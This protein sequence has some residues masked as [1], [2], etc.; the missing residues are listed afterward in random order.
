MSGTLPPL[1]E[2]LLIAVGSALGA[3]A[4][5][6][7]GQCLLRSDFSQPVV[8]TL[9]VN[10][11]GCAVAGF[12]AGFAGPS[13]VMVAGFL[14]AGFLGSYTTVSSLSLEALGMWQSGRTRL[15]TAYVL[16]STVGSLL[17]AWAG[18]WLGVS[19]GLGL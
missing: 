16:A 12:V 2:I 6:G 15:A 14:V 9:A 7:L 11:S 4:R 8:A 13:N 19:S 1:I 3:V 10:L 18:W 5:F 17:S